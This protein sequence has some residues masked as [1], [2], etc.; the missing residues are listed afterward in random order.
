[1]TSPAPLA[2]AVAAQ[3]AYQAAPALTLLPGGAAGAAL[4]LAQ[5][6][7]AARASIATTTLRLVT[8]EFTAVTD[9]RD[10]EVIDAVARTTLRLIQG[11]QAATANSTAAY[12]RA[13]LSQI[14][15]RHVAIVVGAVVLGAGLRALQ[16]PATAYHRAFEQWRFA[17]SIGMPEPEAKAKGL[18]RITRQVDS[19][20][21]MA[22][23]SAVRD[24]LTGTDEA[25]GYRRIL[26][27]E[28]SRGGSCGL[29][30]AAADRTYSKAELLPLHTWCR[31]DVMPMTRRHDPGL[32][33]NEADLARLYAVAGSTAR[34]DLK[35][36][37]V[38]VVDH[39][40]LGPIL[41]SA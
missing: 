6:Q 18:D 5:R 31:C 26:H 15:S 12:L 17:R 25:I 9:P 10:P 37:R 11:G 22:M 39:G 13:V 7:A 3:A 30:V 35:R 38:R 24:V 28:M 34:D 1:M 20:L 33:L 19:D 41:R 23:R 36:V 40:E 27:P 8:R 4:T 14:T 21:S 29:C 16:D 2:E 32:T